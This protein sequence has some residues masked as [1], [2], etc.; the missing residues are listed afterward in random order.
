MLPLAPLTV[1]IFGSVAPA[2]AAPP[3]H[4]R[5][6]AT[7]TP[8]RP[9]LVLGLEQ[10]MTLTIDVHGNDGGAAAFAPER[11]TASIG[12]IASVTPEGP[13]RFRADTWRRRPGSPRSA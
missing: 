5:A 12:S 8:E 11:A 6:H 10:E 3:V 2:P 7:I 13:N 9:H 4:Q 1:M